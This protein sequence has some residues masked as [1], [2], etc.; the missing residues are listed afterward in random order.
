MTMYSGFWN[1]SERAELLGMS[2]MAVPTWRKNWMEASRAW[3]TGPIERMLWID[4]R[5]YLAGDLLVKMDIASMHCGLETR[6]PLLDH[7]LIEFCAGI[8]VKYKVKNGVGK[9]L[10]KRFAEKYFSK[11]FVHRPKMGF[12]IPAAQWMRGPYR[13]LVESLVRDEQT[14]SPL[15]SKVACKQLDL[16]LS[17]DDNEAPRIWALFMFALWKRVCVERGGV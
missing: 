8:E 9:Y 13:S 15:N 2:S 14:I 6:S 7:E 3:A 1:D 12:G 16:F 10:L 11:E 5:T 17:G 4:N